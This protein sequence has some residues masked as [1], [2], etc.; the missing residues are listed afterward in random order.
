MGSETAALGGLIVMNLMV[1]NRVFDQV[2]WPK[3]L[4]V[5]FPTQKALRRFAPLDRVGD[6]VPTRAGMVL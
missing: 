1:W 6:P 3:G 5:S 4:A 2:G